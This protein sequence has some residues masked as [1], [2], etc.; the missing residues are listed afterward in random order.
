MSEISEK[1]KDRL[2]NAIQNLKDCAF[3][4]QASYVP[5]CYSHDGD[6]LVWDEQKKESFI[7]DLIRFA[8]N[9]HNYTP[10]L[11]RPIYLFFDITIKFIA[12]ACRFSE[13][14]FV[15]LRKI[16]KVAYKSDPE[17]KC[18]F[19]YLI[20]AEKEQIDKMFGETTYWSNYSEFITWLIKIDNDLLFAC[21]KY[22]LE[23][24]IDDRALS[25][26]SDT[27]AINNMIT[28]VNRTAS[29]ILAEMR[30]RESS[31]EVINDES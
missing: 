31:L 14:A 10:E 25:A 21:I 11:E 9:K 17:K 6:D 30:K 23:E 27:T 19:E 24:Y 7:H 4:M 13:Q 20:E 2:F 3:G 12:A 5:L 8:S 16:A 29:I 28:R 26:F 18:T 1:N 15:S 22:A